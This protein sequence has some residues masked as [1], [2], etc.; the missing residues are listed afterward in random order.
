[1]QIRRKVYQQNAQHSLPSGSN[2]T[3]REEADTKVLRLDLERIAELADKLKTAGDTLVVQK[4]SRSEILARLEEAIN[5]L[6]TGE[7]FEQI[8]AEIEAGRNEER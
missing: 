2:K 3:A 5:Q 1:M 4:A 8:W 7:P 6:R